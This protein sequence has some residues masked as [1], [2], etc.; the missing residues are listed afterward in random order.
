MPQYLTCYDYG[1]GGIWLY[2]EAGNPAEIAARYRDLTVFETP[3]AWWTDEMEQN[4]R[5][6]QGPFWADWLDGF[7][8]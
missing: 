5:S 8:R 7:R 6:H 1:Q 3:P 2:I 4:A